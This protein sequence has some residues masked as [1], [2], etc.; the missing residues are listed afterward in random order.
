M[1][2]DWFSAAPTLAVTDAC[3][4]LLQ[5]VQARSAREDGDKQVSITQVTTEL[6]SLLP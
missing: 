2:I 4:S 3:S 6:A 5:A 1:D